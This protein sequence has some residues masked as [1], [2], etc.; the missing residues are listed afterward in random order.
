MHD[1]G[2]NNIAEFSLLHDIIN[3]SKH[4]KNTNSHCSPILHGFINTRKSRV[5]HKKSQILSDSRW[6]SIIL[7]RIL[8]S[9]L[10]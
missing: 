7:M 8:A 9:K 10:Y 2:I 4:T 5:R 3:T 6:S 1:N